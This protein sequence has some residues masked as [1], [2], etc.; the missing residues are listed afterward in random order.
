MSVDAVDVMVVADL[1]MP[2]AYAVP[3]EN[4]GRLKNVLAMFRGPSLPS[5]CLAYAV[6]H[7]EAGTILI[8][9]GLHPDASTNLRKD[10]GPAMALF[11]RGIK[12]PA[13]PYLDQLRD[14]GIEPDAVERVI[15]THL[16]VDHTG[17]MRLLPNARFTCAREEW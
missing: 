7:P 8:D 2:E 6:R 11:F 13:R 1:A 16:H 4:A 14:L 9:T 3:D 17:A 10:F 15:M 5:H 12:P